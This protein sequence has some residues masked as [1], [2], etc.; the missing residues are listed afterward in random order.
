M[1]TLQL[2]CLVLR[3]HETTV[4]K[5]LRRFI[6]EA[7]TKKKC[8]KMSR[9]GFYTRRGQRSTLAQNSLA[10]QWAKQTQDNGESRIIKRVSPVDVVCYKSV[11]S[12]TSL[13][14]S[15]LRAERT[16]FFFFFFSGNKI[17]GLSFHCT[18]ALSQPATSPPTASN[19][20]ATCLH[21]KYRTVQY[22]RAKVVGNT[23]ETPFGFAGLHGI[24]SPL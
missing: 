3:H 5:A 12:R 20:S 10:P 16:S 2:L 18:C 14:F 24:P 15:F 7:D 8:V 9:T 23:E 13:G 11:Y 17:H 21:L 1:H 19:S 4:K 6:R 22:V